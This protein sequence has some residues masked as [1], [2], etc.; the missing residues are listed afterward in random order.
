[1]PVDPCENVGQYSYSRVEV[2][3]RIDTPALQPNSSW[4]CL[5]SVEGLPHPPLDAHDTDSLKALLLAIG[6]VRGCLER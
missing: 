2:V 3:V 1:M 4:L 6:N 5:A